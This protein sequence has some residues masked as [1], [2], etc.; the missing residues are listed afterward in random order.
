MAGERD[1]LIHL[2]GGLSDAEALHHL[3]AAG[4]PAA[5][6]RRHDDRGRPHARLVAGVPLWHSEA[7]SAEITEEQKT[8]VGSRAAELAEPWIG[9]AWDEL[10]ARLATR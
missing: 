2:N 3:Q 4:H 8:S 5:E 6:V 9:L 10:S 1:E 7:A